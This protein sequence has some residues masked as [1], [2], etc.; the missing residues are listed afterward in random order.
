MSKLDSPT[1]FDKIKKNYFLNGVEDV[2]DLLL[3]V[4]PVFLI[5]CA[6]FIGQK[7][8]G[9]DIRS[10]SM[11]AIYLLSPF[12]V[13]RTFYENEL[14]MDYVYIMLFCLVLCFGLIFFIWMIGSIMGATRQ[15]KSGMV[16]GSVFMNSGN[17]GTPIVLFAF[18]TIGFDYAVIM[19]VFQSFLMNTVGLFFASI[20]SKEETSLKEAVM[21]VVRMPVLHGAILGVLFQLF[22]VELAKPFTD[23]IDLVANASI[24]TFM[25]VLGMQLAE[26]TRKRVDYRSVSIMT[27]TRMVL[28]PLFAAV[29]LSFMPINDLLR[30]VLIVQAAMPTAVNTTLFALQFDAEPDLVSFTTFITTLLSLITI[31]LVLFFV[32]VS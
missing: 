5:L 4:L 22:S 10:I 24:P 7:F 11:V 15:K 23:A 18:G 17:Y 9:F 32:G 29:I 1:S 20:G 2:F 26:I 27:V 8:I 19:M 14:T 3:I 25:L 28:S 6:G 16:L 21:R 13:F 31:P 12:L 30:S